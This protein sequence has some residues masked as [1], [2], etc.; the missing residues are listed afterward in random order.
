MFETLMFV[1]FPLVVVSAC[2]RQR[3]VVGVADDGAHSRW[4]CISGS[5]LSPEGA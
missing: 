5:G 3:R 4:G 2:S 1:L